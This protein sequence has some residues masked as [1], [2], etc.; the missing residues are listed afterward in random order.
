MSVAGN[1]DFSENAIKMEQRH[2]IT[3]HVVLQLRDK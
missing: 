2:K 1:R 3:G